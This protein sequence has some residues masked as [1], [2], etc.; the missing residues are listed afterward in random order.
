MMVSA[1]EPP[2]PTNLDAA[3]AALLEILSPEQVDG[4]RTGSLESWQYHHGLGTFIR[5]EWI[6]HGQLGRVFADLNLGSIDAMSGIV[7]ESFV[8]KLRGQPFD[9]IARGAEISAAAKEYSA[10]MRTPDATSPT[11]RSPIKWVCVKGQGKGAVHTGFSLSDG[12]YWRWVYGGSGQVDPA[13]P[14]EA[15]S[16]KSSG[17]GNAPDGKG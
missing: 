13:T 9:L 12:T 15:A 2:K 14:E 17:W 11:D 16:L 6:R 4:L 3:H 7:L 5:N 10:S 1:A 8:C